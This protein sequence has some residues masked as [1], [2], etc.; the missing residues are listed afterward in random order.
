MRGTGVI[1]RGG[2]RNEPDSQPAGCLSTEPVRPLNP[3]PVYSI[4]PFFCRR[5][6]RHKETASRVPY[7][8]N[9]F[10]HTRLMQK[11]MCLTPEK[12]LS[13]L[14]RTQVQGTEYRVD[15]AVT[16]RLS[17]KCATQR[18]GW[19]RV[20]GAETGPSYGG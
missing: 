18:R 13:S 14:R 20:C 17:M 7:V 10:F 8:F 4:K 1:G 12:K 19:D 6:S 5:W 3:C 11:K 15:T 9:L 16:R 2:Y